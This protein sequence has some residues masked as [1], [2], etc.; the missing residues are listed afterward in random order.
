M[1]AC[2]ASFA[3]YIGARQ[4]LLEQRVAEDADERMRIELAR[5][6]A[7]DENERKF[8]HARNHIIEEIINCHCPRCKQAFVD[9]DACFAL[10]C[11][12]CPCGFC[13]WCG[14]D[15]GGA[16]AHAHV[17]HCRHKPAGADVFFGS[18]QDF[19]EAQDRRR[20][21]QL[22]PY[23]DS[24]DDATR[25]EVLRTCANELRGLL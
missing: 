17:R 21:R 11:S 14:E 3:V 5:L 20:K 4:R 22:R 18:E 25:E 15:S 10:K 24:L 19:N 8:L 1:A 13:A 6:V 2:A 16:D 23:L 9:F 12:R 7:L